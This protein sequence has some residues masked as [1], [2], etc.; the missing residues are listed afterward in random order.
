MQHDSKTTL[1]FDTLRHACRAQLTNEQVYLLLQLFTAGR[2]T[3]MD[4]AQRDCTALLLAQMNCA[5]HYRRQHYPVMIIRQQ[6]VE[7]ADM[8]QSTMR[9]QAHAQDMA[10][11]K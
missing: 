1:P 9:H 2:I 7:D 11:S 4:N 8:A 10:G 6:H 5:R 3:L